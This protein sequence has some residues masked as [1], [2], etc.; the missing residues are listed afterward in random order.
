M[1]IHEVEKM[2]EIK[3]YACMA[4][5]FMIEYVRYEKYTH[6]EFTYLVPDWVISVRNNGGKTKRRKLQC[7]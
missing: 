6:Y 4:R 5:F 3:K 1:R 7:Q 2:K